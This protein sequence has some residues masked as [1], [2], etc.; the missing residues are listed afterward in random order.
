MNLR[1][2]AARVSSTAYRIDK[3]GE[4]NSKV[5]CLHYSILDQHRGRFSDMLDLVAAWIPATEGIPTLKARSDVEHIDMDIGVF[6]EEEIAG[7]SFTI[8]PKFLRVISDLGFSL[9]LSIYK[10]D[11]GI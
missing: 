6:I 2:V 1:D 9:T 7:R 10:S 8:S 3:V 5:N 4:K 11:S